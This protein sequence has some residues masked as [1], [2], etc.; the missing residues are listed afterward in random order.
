MSH[1]A[2]PQ[3]GLR[4]MNPSALHEASGNAPVVQAR[5]RLLVGN[6]RHNAFPVIARWRERFY[7]AYREAD[8]HAGPG[9]LVLLSSADAQHWSEVRRV[10][11]APDTRDPALLA[12]PERLFLYCVTIENKRL[13]SWG[14]ATDDG[15]TFTEPRPI[16]AEGLVMWRPIRHADVFYSTAYTN[17]PTE[18]RRLELLRSDDGLNW[19]AVGIIGAPPGLWSETA[20]CI[21][22][23]QRMTAFVRMKYSVQRPEEPAWGEVWQ[24]QPPYADWRKTATLPFRIEGPGVFEMA[25]QTYLITRGFNRIGQANALNIHRWRDEQLQLHCAI[26]CMRDCAYGHAVEH[27]GGLLVVFYCTVPDGVN[28]YLAQVPGA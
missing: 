13:Q 21:D 12:T 5:C 8:S 1:A 27:E 17:G 4:A 24:A 11:V 25:G 22:A 15:R 16:F 26:P 28:L 19:Q 10:K 2:D 6:G 23:Q 3:A 18:E 9:E 20:I 7:I 14:C